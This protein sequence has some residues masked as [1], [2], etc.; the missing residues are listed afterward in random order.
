VGKDRNINDSQLSPFEQCLTKLRNELPSLGDLRRTFR[1]RPSSFR[2]NT[3]KT[4]SQSIIEE[5]QRVGIKLK[6]PNWSKVTCLVPTAAKRELEALNAYERGEIYLQSLASQVPPLVLEPQPGERVLDMCAAPGGKTAQIAALMN[7]EG[8][9]VAIEKDRIRAERLSFN[10]DRQGVLNAPKL[11]VTVV[12]GDA[13]EA[14]IIGSFDRILI[15]APCS[16]EARFIANKRDT[17]RHWGPEFVTELSI[18]Q[19]AL[20]KRA[21][22]LLKPGGLLVYSTCTF[23]V[24]ENEL[25]AAEALKVGYRAEPFP[26]CFD[27]GFPVIQAS[28]SLQGKTHAIGA[29]IKPSDE[30]EG[31][32]ISRLRAPK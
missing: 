10:L 28:V 12:I 14:E 27:N 1:E 3:L 7:G 32:F 17:W 11:A 30:I 5:C 2:I 26:R 13:L 20:L 8:E 18:L 24:A 25:I 16:G 4:N 23:S 31:F 29:R 6:R 9:L 19:R 21:L 22:T 15:D